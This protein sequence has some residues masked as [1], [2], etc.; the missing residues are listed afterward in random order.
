MVRMLYAE[1]QYMCPGG[2]SLSGMVAG[3]I[4]TWK[5]LLHALKISCSKD[6]KSPYVFPQL[7]LECFHY[8]DLFLSCIL[9]SLGVFHLF[10]PVLAHGV[11]CCGTVLPACPSWSYD[12]CPA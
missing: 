11:R 4:W 2:D 10:E 7:A 6:F 5:N 3:G 9:A 8:A 1:L 12:V